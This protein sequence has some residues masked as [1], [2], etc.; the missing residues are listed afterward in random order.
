MDVLD[1]YVKSAPSNQS[2][3]DIFRG[4]WSSKLPPE[5]R[6][7]STPG[8]AALFEDRRI[9]WLSTQIGGFR[10]KTILELG[11][12][13][14][15]HTYMMHKAGSKRIV[16]IEANTRSYLKC[17]CIREIS[18]MDGVDFKLGDA[19]E[20]MRTCTETFDVCVASGILYHVLDPISF[21]GLLA[22]MSRSLFIWTHIYDEE[23]IKALGPGARQ[24]SIPFEIKRNENVYR[25]SER[26]YQAALSWSGFCG[27][28]SESALWLDRPSL[29]KAL[30]VAGFDDVV[31][32]SEDLDHPNGPAITLLARR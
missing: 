29:L 18:N 23:L 17:L 16:A 22:R 13:E 8:T 25:V 12:L 9:D 11:P 7:I 14:A 27:G 28:N 26:A 21:I 30:H 4:E 15:G 5:L 24:F 6:A 20:F 1:Q 2:V 3:V 19:A 31:I 32:G 10:D